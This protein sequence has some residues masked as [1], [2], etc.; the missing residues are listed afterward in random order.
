MYI[1]DRHSFA[2]SIGPYE[3]TFAGS[4]LGN[5]EVFLFL[6]DKLGGGK[7]RVTYR[8][9]DPPA[10]I[11]LYPYQ[12]VETQVF[13]FMDG[14]YNVATEKKQKGKWVRF[15]VDVGWLLWLRVVN[16]RAELKLSPETRATFA[17]ILRQLQQ[18][19]R[20]AISVELADAP[21]A[22]SPEGRVFLW[23]IKN[24]HGIVA[25]EQAYSIDRRAIAGAIAW[26][27]LQNAKTFPGTELATSAG[28]ALFSG[29]GKVHYKEFRYKEGITA[30]IEVELLGRLPV[31]T[32]ERRR[33]I[34]ATTPG[35]L[36]YIGTIMRAFSDVAAQGG[37]Y[38]DCDPPMLATYYNAWNINQAAPFFAQ[39]RAPAPLTPN[40][41]GAWVGA[42]MTFIERTVGKP[43][44]GFCKKPRGY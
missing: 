29:P 36:C 43:P 33:Q 15:D 1:Y 31:Q 9:E 26:E 14:P 32:M 28:A 3:G 24:I 16:G 6:N 25:T 5:A 22:S 21:E 23:L 39:R 27:A 17:E 11:E 2:E 41:M 18:P 34:L 37:Y 30:A 13:K 44:T 40:E 7:H 42:N 38:L 20:A 8:T 19:G 35:A 4:L 10:G 12:R